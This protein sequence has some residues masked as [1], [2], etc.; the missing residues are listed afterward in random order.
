MTDRR[1]VRVVQ[2]FF[3][4]LDELL[5]DERGVDGAPSSA[6]FLLHDMPA[7]ID[8]LAESYDSSTVPIV[9][10]SEIRVLITSGHLVEFMA[11]YTVLDVDGVVQIVYLEIAGA[12]ED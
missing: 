4:R 11:V 9:A 7:V 1:R 8:R 10:G 2:A 5:A 6:D 3:D 12:D